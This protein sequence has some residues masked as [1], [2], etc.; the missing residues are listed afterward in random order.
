M[1]LP[2]RA[3]GGPQ[4][5]TLIQRQFY[6]ARSQT[7]GSKAMTVLM[8]SEKEIQALPRG[9]DDPNVRQQRFRAFNK[10]V[11]ALFDAALK[12]EGPVSAE[13]IALVEKDAISALRDHPETL[14]EML[15][16]T[17]EIEIGVTCRNSKC[18]SGW[19]WDRKY[20]WQKYMHLHCIFNPYNGGISAW[21]DY[22]DPTQIHHFR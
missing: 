20:T 17:Y 11:F 6:S 4:N 10:A 3:L 14:A 7:E 18:G 19:W 13:R 22:K 2:Y 12:E 16:Y 5:T 21:T 8:F 15:C 9:T 1:E